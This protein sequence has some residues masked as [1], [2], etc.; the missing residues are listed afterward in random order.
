[1]ADRKPDLLGEVPDPHPRW[2]DDPYGGVDVTMMQ[3][4]LKMTPEE[5]LRYAVDA[6]NFF[7][8]LRGL[9]LKR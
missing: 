2:N 6:A 5:R 1:M 9:A 3:E 4:L 7:G 8:P